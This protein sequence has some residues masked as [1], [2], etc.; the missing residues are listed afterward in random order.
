MDKERLTTFE[1]AVL[2]IIMTILVLELKKPDVVSLE[3]LWMLRSNFFAYGLSFFWIGL[4]WVSHHNNWRLVQKIDLTTIYLTLL[5]L[6]FSSLF[7][8]TTSLVADNF[9]NA[10]A[11]ALYG[12]VIILI[13]LTNVLISLNLRSVNPQAHFGLLYK[14][15]NWIV[16]LDLVIKGIGFI[17]SLMFFAPAMMISI[18]LASLAI[19]VGLAQGRHESNGSAREIHMEPLEDCFGS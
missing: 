2:A 17:T 19:V 11:Q 13:S 10:T 16:C 3:G 8:Y 4:M 7:P 12:V 9:S 15:P 1:D 14:T 6:F 5:L 18:F